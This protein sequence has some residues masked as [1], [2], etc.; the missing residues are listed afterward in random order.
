MEEFIGETVNKV[1]M[2]NADVIEGGEVQM[3]RVKGLGNSRRYIRVRG[4]YDPKTFTI[5]DARWAVDSTHDL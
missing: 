3:A 2:G 1:V 5:M 4:V